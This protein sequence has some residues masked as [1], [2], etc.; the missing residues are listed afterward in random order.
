MSD[1]QYYRD[2]LGWKPS[3][4]ED[5]TALHLTNGHEHAKFDPQTKQLVDSHYDE[6][7][8]YN[9]PTDLVKHMGQSNL[10]KMVLVGAAVLGLWALSKK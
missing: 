5:L 4:G 6:I 10:G 2:L 1:F 8:P 3:I 9:S 7:D